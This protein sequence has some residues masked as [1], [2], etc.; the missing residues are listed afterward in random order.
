MEAALLLSRILVF[1]LICYIISLILKPSPKK[2][3]TN[4]LD[5]IHEEAI[6]LSKKKDKIRSVT[7]NTQE[8]LKKINKELKK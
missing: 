6:D 4:D 7:G 5:K 8:K 3:S 1:L 2:E